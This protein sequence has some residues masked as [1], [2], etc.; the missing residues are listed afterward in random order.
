MHS[1][2]KNKLVY[3]LFSTVKNTQGYFFLYHTQ[4][5]LVIG[6]TLKTISA[7]HA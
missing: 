4:S 2:K 6:L 3:K 5:Y 7:I 1:M